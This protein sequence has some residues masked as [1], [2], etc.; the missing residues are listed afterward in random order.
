M[1][2]FKNHSLNKYIKT[3]HK[4]FENK[5]NL[6]ISVVFKPWFKLSFSRCHI[7]NKTISKFQSKIFIK[8]FINEETKSKEMK[9]F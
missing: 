7:P 3:F 8:F 6:H 2:I 4:N 9:P 5:F 1:N